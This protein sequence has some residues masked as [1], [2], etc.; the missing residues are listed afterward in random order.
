[1]ALSA[2]VDTITVS[3]A[4]LR[5]FVRHLFIAIGVPPEDAEIT[6][7]VLVEADLT[8]RHTHGVSR[9]PL[10]VNRLRRGLIDPRPSLTWEEPRFPGLRVLDGGNGLGPVVAWR[11][12]EEAVKLSR[13][14]GMAGIAVRQ[15]NHAGAMSVYCEEAARHGQILLALTNSPPGIPP[16]GGRTAFLGTNPIA[17]A[18]PRGE[19]KPPLVIDLATSVVARG[20][21]IQAARLHQPIPEGWAIDEDGY[22]TT[23]AEKALKGAVLPMAGPKGYA[24]A[25][26]VEIFSGV[27]SGAGIG[28]GVKNPYNDD[29]GPANVGHFFWALNPSGF[30]SIDDLYRSLAVLEAGLRGVPPMPGQIVRMPGDRAEE[31]R[32]Q[33]RTHGIPLDRDLYN[34]LNSLAVACRAP[35]LVPS[36]RE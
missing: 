16:W 20:N 2:N 35:A 9:L 28:P 5:E 17:V 6:A 3:E 29:S 25:I 8:G 7:T 10:Y 11:A 26:M 24:L 12:M 15:S 23:D 4:T 13:L 14:Y 33:Y 18:F 27:L 30:G 36:Q 32:Q 19:D 1:M 31:Q 22:P 21:I 34:Q